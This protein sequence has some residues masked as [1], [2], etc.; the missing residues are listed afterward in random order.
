MESRGSDV[1]PL[2][3]VLVGDAVRSSSCSCRRRVRAADWVRQH[4]KPAAGASH[5]APEGDRDS[6]FTRRWTAAYR[7]ATADGEPDAGARR[8]RCGHRCRYAAIRL[9]RQQRPG[10]RAASARGRAAARGAALRLGDH[11]ICCSGLRHGT[12]D[13][14]G[15]TDLQAS[16]RDAGK[17]SRRR[18]PRDRLRSLMVVA[19]V[20][21][22]VVLLVGTGLLVRSARRLRRS[23]S[24]STRT[25]CS[26]PAF[27]FPLH[28]TASGC[29]RP[30]PTGGCWSSAGRSRAG[31]QAGAPPMFRCSAAS[32][33]PRSP[34]RERPRAGAMPSPLFRLVTDDYFEAVG[35]TIV[36]GRPLQPSDML[37]GRAA[38]RRDQRAAGRDSCGPVKIPSAGE[39]RGGPR[40]RSRN[41]ARSSAWSPMSELWPDHARS[42]GDVPAL[43]TGACRFLGCLSAK[44]GPR[45]ACRCDWPETYAPAMRRAV[46]QVDRVDSAL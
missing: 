21:V 8:W 43:H 7:P 46:S 27:P 30:K 35:M 29:R 11:H 42:T 32:S 9:L 5:H 37:E 6:G 10:E 14:R 2:Q 3:D 22:T 24:A 45:P 28:V 40:A 20:A 17:S 38:G 16:L 41:G 36:R 23:R 1:Q 4:R 34:P 26:P 33:R 44:H 13:S 31:A 18:C 19:E 39:C 15:A 25:M 12:G